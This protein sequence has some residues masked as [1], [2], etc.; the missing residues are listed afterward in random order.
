MSDVSG[1]IMASCR[2]IMCKSIDTKALPFFLREREEPGN[3]ATLNSQLMGASLDAVWT[4]SL[5]MNTED[6]E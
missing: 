5:N 6:N 3:K 2:N 1:C 4:K